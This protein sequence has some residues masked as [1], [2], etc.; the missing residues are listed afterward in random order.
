MLP[1]ENG[2]SSNWSDSKRLM[3][4]KEMNSNSSRLMFA[5]K[6][7]LQL[8]GVSKNGKGGRIMSF[9]ALTVVG[10]VDGAVGYG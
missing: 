8:I 6:D 10:D 5:R 3:M 7:G 2:L 9:A 1:R 4:A